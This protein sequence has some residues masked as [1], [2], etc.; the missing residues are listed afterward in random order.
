MDLVEVS[1]ISLEERLERLRKV[2]EELEESLR[3]AA[4]L[5]ARQHNR[6][7]I[8]MTFA[9]GDKVLLSTK[10]LN[11]RRPSKKLDGMFEGPFKIIDTVGKQA[12]TLRQPRKYGRIHPTFH[13]SLLKPWTPRGPDGDTTER[14][15]VIDNEEEIEWEVEQIIAHRKRGRQTQYL[16]KWVGFP[17]FENSWE[18]TEHLSSA[19][20]LVKEYKDSQG[21]A[22]APRRRRRR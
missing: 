14:S 1:K 4:E 13:V 10:N 7:H 11:T 16:V 2:R 6:T 5:Q 19:K 18:P 20:D 17:E 3:H 8:P 12:Y 15:Q 22:N 21:S 9:I